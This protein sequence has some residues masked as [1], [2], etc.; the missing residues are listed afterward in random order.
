ME[1]SEFV[2][3]FQVGNIENTTFHLSTFITEI[4]LMVIYC[5]FEARKGS[6]SRLLVYLHVYILFLG[7]SS[8]LL[9]TK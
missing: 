1:S 5:F 3:V 7:K 4:T 2:F 8:P 6:V 9:P